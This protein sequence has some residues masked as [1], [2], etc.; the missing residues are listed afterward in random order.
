M[1]EQANSEQCDTGGNSAGC[2]GV[3]SRQARFHG[4]FLLPVRCLQCVVQNGFTCNTEALPST[5]T[6]T[7]GS[8]SGTELVAS[9]TTVTYSFGLNV[10]RADLG[11]AFSNEGAC[12]GVGGA[13]FTVEI[14]PGVVTAGERALCPLAALR[15]SV[16][17]PCVCACACVHVCC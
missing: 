2:V 5:C 4:T 14:P 1:T 6:S 13:V 17:D 12:Q 9:N 11:W 3:R 10:V 7:S 16:F 8:G 15:A